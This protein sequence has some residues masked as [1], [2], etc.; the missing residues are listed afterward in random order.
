[1]WSYFL[2]ALLSNVY[3]ALLFLT[4]LLLLVD[5]IRL[6]LETRIALCIFYLLLLAS[7]A[8]SILAGVISSHTLTGLLPSLVGYSKAAHLQEV[9]DIT[10]VRLAGLTTLTILFIGLFVSVLFTRKVL[11]PVVGITRAATDIS[12]GCYNT[13]SLNPLEK[14]GDELGNLARVFVDMARQVAVREKRLNQ[15]IQ[16]LEIVIDRQEEQQRI[17]EVTESD[18]FKNLEAQAQAM[19]RRKGRKRHAKESD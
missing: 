1:M 6:T 17:A 14:R 13:S 5:K 3:M 8:V 11:G 9:F 19:R 4:P 2:S 12:N 7:M 15:R 10:M 18:Y 16:D